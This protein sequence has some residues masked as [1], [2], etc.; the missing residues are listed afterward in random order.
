MIAFGQSAEEF[1]TIQ[2]LSRAFVR[3]RPDVSFV[4]IGATFDDFALMATGNLFVSGAVETADYGHVLE[5]YRPDKLLIAMRRPLFGHPAAA[6]ARQDGAPIAY[7]DWSF[8]KAKTRSADLPI[9]PRVDD[10]TL[11]SLMSDWMAGIS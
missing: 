3:R 7:F 9:D 8:G 2:T 6:A 11:V 5:Q 1:K 10:Q 4:V